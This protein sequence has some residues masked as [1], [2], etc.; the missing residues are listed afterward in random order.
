MDELISKDKL[1]QEAL[2][3]GGHLYSDWDTGGV[4]AL[5]VRQP[6]V[7]AKAIEYAHWVY[8]PNGLDWGISAWVCSSCHCVNKN[9]PTMNMDIAPLNPLL[10]S[11]SKFCPNCGKT[12]ILEKKEE[13]D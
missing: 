6:K 7:E 4:L 11:G 12:M 9:I 13:K 10:F 3:I 5:I 2:K 8:D 1:I